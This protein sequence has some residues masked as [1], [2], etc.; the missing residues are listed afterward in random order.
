MMME[1]WMGKTEKGDGDE[2][3]LEDASRY[4]KSGVQLAWLGRE[5]LVSV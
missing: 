5:D 2:N 3:D 4:V 1:L